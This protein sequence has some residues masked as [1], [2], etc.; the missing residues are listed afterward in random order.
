MLQYLALL[1]WLVWLLRS[2]DMHKL[3][4]SSL[5]LYARFPFLTFADLPAGVLQGWFREAG[6][7]QEELNSAWG[8][9]LSWELQDGVAPFQTAGQGSQ[10]H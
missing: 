6:G 7:T 8:I 9:L 1:A 10:S 5:A 3:T 4:C 2:R